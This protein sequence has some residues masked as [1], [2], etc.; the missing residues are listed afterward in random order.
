MGR[1]FYKTFILS[2]NFYSL[3]PVILHDSHEIKMKNLKNFEFIAKE[4]LPEDIFE[5]YSGGACDGISLQQNRE[6]FDNLKLLPRIL[7]DVSAINTRT[8]LFGTPQSMPVL[9][10]PMSF[11]QMAHPDGEIATVKAS[12]QAGITMIASLMSNQSLEDIS[13]HSRN[14]LWFQ[15]YVL[16]DMDFTIDLLQRAE[17]AN[18]KAIVLTVDSQTLGIRNYSNQKN[19][20]L[21]DKY[22]IPNLNDYKQFTHHFNNINLFDKQLTWKDVEWIKMNTKLPVIL[23]GILNP[24]D[25]KIAIENKI[26]GIIISNH[27][28][29]QLDTTV[30]PI[31]ILPEIAD[32]V[33]GSLPLFIDGAISR[34]TD[35]LKAI[36]LGADAVLVGRPILWGLATNGSAGVVETLEILKKELEVAMALSGFNSIKDLKA[37]GHTIIYQ[38][39]LFKRH[40]L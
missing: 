36:A 23:K 28:G 5:Y 2:I 7:I 18:Y 11:Q 38:A 37:A 15:L 35:I 31:L 13:S 17:A 26:D 34:G 3:L 27:G 1:L 24:A 30:S 22:K 32:L 6:C 14:N 16:N 39:D 20:K 21:P 25:A 10:A 8:E 12:N 19:F 9:I 29:R 4:K 40:T 33:A